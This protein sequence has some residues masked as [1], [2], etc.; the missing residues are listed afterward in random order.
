MM[1]PCDMIVHI[2]VLTIGARSNS[3]VTN[4][5]IV[6]AAF[7]TGVLTGLFKL[8]WRAACCCEAAKYNAANSQHYGIHPS[9]LHMLLPG[10]Q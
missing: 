9:V 10:A 6:R 4:R 2:Q 7:E 8:Q 3:A 5:Y 1:M